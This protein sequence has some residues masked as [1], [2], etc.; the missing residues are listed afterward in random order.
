MRYIKGCCLTSVMMSHI[1]CGL[2]RKCWV[3]FYDGCLLCNDHL[4]AFLPVVLEFRF[5]GNIL[6]ETDINTYW[7]FCGSIFEKILECPYNVCLWELSMQPTSRMILML[8]LLQQ[9]ILGYFLRGFNHLNAVWSSYSLYWHFTHLIAAFI[10]ELKFLAPSKKTTV[11]EIGCGIGLVGL[12]F[13]KVRM[14]YQAYA[15]SAHSF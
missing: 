2:I 8:T 3:M 7:E 15:C 6:R 11:V 12:Y 9:N 4:Q 14:K 5:F 1:Y 10:L 13:S